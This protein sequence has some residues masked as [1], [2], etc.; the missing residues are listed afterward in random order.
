MWADA[1]DGSLGT[2]KTDLRVSYGTGKA[3]RFRNCGWCYCRYYLS[4]STIVIGAEPA[5]RTFRSYQRTRGFGCSSAAPSVTF[6]S[7][8]QSHCVRKGDLATA[9][10]HGNIRDR[11]D[12]CSHSTN[13]SLRRRLCGHGA[14]HVAER[15]GREHFL[16]RDRRRN[17]AVFGGYLYQ[18]ESTLVSEGV[19]KG[20]MNM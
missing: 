5:A 1:P 8:E 15:H 7:G 18:K 2:A 4:Y 17:I 9:S 19:M 11:P 12:P 6:P 20:P 16:A 10:K 13:Q 3:R 14:A